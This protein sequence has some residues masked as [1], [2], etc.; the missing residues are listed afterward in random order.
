MVGVGVWVG[1]TVGVSVT[2]GV[3]V[4]NKGGI[5]PLLEAKNNPMQEP[6]NTINNINR[7]RMTQSWGNI[8][9]GTA[10]GRAGRGRAAALAVLVVLA[11]LAGGGAAGGA[12]CAG[13][14]RAR[15]SK[16]LNNWTFISAME[17]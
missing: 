17:A 13:W 7:A 3:G 11:T 8:F 2:V 15:A 12:G 6:P 10:A 9:A 16:S 1:V 14:L 5:I 4:G